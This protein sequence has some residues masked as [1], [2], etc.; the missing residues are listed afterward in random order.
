MVEAIYD[1]SS[2]YFY[3]V[4]TFNHIGTLVIMGTHR[5]HDIANDTSINE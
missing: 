2:G 3:V 5:S 1:M 4:E